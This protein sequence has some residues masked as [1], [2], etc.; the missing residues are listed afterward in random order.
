MGLTEDSAEL[1][2]WMVSGPEIA[3]CVNEFETH[4][5]YHYEEEDIGI[6]H[7]EQTSSRQ[8][9]VSAQVLNLVKVISSMDNPFLE[10]SQDLL[11]LDTRN[12]MHENVINTI[13]TIEKIGKEQFH[14]FF[15]DRLRTRKKSLFDPISK[16]NLPIFSRAT[17][18]LTK[19]QSQVASLKKNC[20]LFS[21][22][23]IS[24]QVRDGN[25]EEFFCHENQ[26][27]PPALSKDG[28][29]RSGTKSDLLTCLEEIHLSTQDVP[30]VECIILDGPA[31]VNILSHV[32]LSST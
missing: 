3:R 23:Y 32:C 25:L 29:L 21:Q 16:N 30:V 8:H 26:T 27:F 4:L 20:Q 13:N 15:E 11:V 12:I 5:P 2:R 1:L 6:K 31:I 18:K 9:R 24:C 22:L 7:H 17:K 14:K 19:D 28:S 10:Q